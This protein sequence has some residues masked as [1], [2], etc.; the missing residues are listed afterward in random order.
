[1]HLAMVLPRLVGVTW[2]NIR[3]RYGAG[4]WLFCA[5]GGCVFTGSAWQR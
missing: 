5:D 3:S 2:M 1:M 4:R